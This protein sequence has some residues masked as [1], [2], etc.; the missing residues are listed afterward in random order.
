M[1][2]F[3]HSKWRLSRDFLPISPANILINRCTR[4][5][6]LQSSEKGEGISSHLHMLAGE[7]GC[8]QGFLCFISR[9]SFGDAQDK[10]FLVPCS[11]RRSDAI[12]II[13]TP[14]DSLTWIQE[15]KLHNLQQKMLHTGTEL[16]PHIY[17]HMFHFLCVR[18]SNGKSY[19]SGILF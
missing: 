10:R 13:P 16:Y 1:K 5:T 11:S 19:I 3:F 18:F 4:M 7:S 6:N 8:S 9:F 14:M 15:V 12:I 2:P 17:K